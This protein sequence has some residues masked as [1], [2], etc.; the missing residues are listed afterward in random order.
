M[1]P[2]HHPSRLARGAVLA[3][4]VALLSSGAQAAGR[5][6][7]LPHGLGNPFPGSQGLDQGRALGRLD[8]LPAQAQT[9][10][11][12][13]Q[14]RKQAVDELVRR[15]PAVI[16]RDPAGAPIRR[17]ELVVL[18]PSAALLDAAASAGFLRLRR[19]TLTGLGLT[20]VVLGIPAGMPG[21]AG[22]EAL[23][24]LDPDADFNHLYQ[25][26]GGITGPRADLA[27]APGSGAPSAGAEARVGLIDSGVDGE[28]PALRDIHLRRSG[29]DQPHPSAHGT[30]VASLLVGR[31]APFAGAAPGYQLFAADVY[32][33]DPAGGSAEAVVVALSGMARE[34]VPVINLS[35]VGPPNRLL[36]HAVAALVA[37]G[38]LLV[39]AVGNDGP[40][41]PPLYPAA[42]PGVVAVTGV[43]PHR[44]VLP[45]AGRG[46]HVQFAA[47]GSQLAAAAQGTRGFRPVRGT[48]FAAPLVAGLLA[49]RLAQPDPRL[50]AAA[51]Q[52]LGATARDLGEPGRDPVFG[53]GLVGEGLRSDA[54]DLP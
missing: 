53:Y 52:A 9:A 20:A 3:T 44:H 36:E 22:L 35:L 46:P 14:A 18:D 27:A 51:V 47:P 28:H 5:P 54:D 12:L 40:A 13:A 10:Q 4:L 41:A 19:T 32:C 30:A 16:D 11:Q 21:A 37:R 8:E 43:D 42:Y 25:H 15:N 48:S 38:H 17:G 45:E 50:A 33:D 49:R 31:L 6:L 23:R 24:R 7:G 2:R 34:R 29:C 39:A 1:P 26:A